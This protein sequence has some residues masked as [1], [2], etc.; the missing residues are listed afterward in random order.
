MDF[1]AIGNELKCFN[2]MTSPR[3]SGKCSVCCR[4]GRHGVRR[5]DLVPI[6]KLLKHALEYGWMDDEVGEGEEELTRWHTLRCCIDNGCR[7][8]T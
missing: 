1:E 2:W 5:Y 3:C 6:E 7:S 8:S 4:H